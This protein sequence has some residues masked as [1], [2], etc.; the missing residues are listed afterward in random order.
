MFNIIKYLEEQLIPMGLILLLLLSIR[1]LTFIERISNNKS[2]KTIAY[3]VIVI[4]YFEILIK[5]AKIAIN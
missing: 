3:I 4:Y 2:L 1:D 5:I